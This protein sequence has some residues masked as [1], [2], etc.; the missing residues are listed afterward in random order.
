VVPRGRP[1]ESSSR[2][3]GR[4]V[5][6]PDAA[7]RPAGG[8]CRGFGREGASP[9]CTGL[10]DHLP[11][12]RTA[13]SRHVWSRRATDCPTGCGANRASL[14][15]NDSAITQPK[16]DAGRPSPLSPIRPT[17]PGTA[18]QFNLSAGRTENTAPD[19]HGPY[20]GGGAHRRP[21]NPH[22]P[23]GTSKVFRLQPEGGAESPLRTWVTLRGRPRDPMG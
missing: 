17:T 10:A 16:D 21:L 7:R 3:A 15:A 1:A 6:D 18:E 8:P 2:L 4:G 19:T 23:P 14:L 5:V 22:K 13:L 12:G 9:T 11:G 20:T